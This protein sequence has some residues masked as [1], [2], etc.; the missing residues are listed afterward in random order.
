MR[1]GSSGKACSNERGHTSFREGAAAT[2]P[3]ELRTVVKFKGKDQAQ[4]YEDR[5][6]FQGTLVELI[7]RTI[8]WIDDRMYHGG[9]VPE[10]GE[11]RGAPRLRQHGI[12][13][14]R[15]DVR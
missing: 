5:K 7:D 14:H 13:H 3:D 9:K 12:A 8:A 15:E 4:G 2:P 6:D 11:R 10:R 1:A